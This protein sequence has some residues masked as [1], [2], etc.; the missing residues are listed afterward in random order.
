MMKRVGKYMREKRR[1]TEMIEAPG[2]RK[3]IS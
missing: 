1:K 2:L 3:E